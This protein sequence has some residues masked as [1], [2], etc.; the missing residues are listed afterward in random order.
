MTGADHILTTDELKARLGCETAG[1][2]KRVLRKDGIVYF[3]NRDKPWTTLDM[4]NA[5]GRK[6]MGEKD[7]AENDDEEGVM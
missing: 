3:G 7:D 1:E 5:A 2:L 6:K 4:I